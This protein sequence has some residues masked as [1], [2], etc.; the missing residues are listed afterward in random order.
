MNDKEKIFKV[1][2]WNFDPYMLVLKDFEVTFG[3]NYYNFSLVA[4]WNESCGGC[5]EYIC[6]RVH[7]DITK[8]LRHVI[9]IG[10]KYDGSKHYA[11]VRYEWLTTFCYRCG[12][13]GH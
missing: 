13:I 7:I 12:I 9:L 11:L 1:R 10:L 8:P 3:L 5:T 2:L 4:F 6:T